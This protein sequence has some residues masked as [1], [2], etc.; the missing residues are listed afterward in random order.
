MQLENLYIQESTEYII[1]VLKADLELKGIHRFADIKPNRKNIQTQCPFHKDGQERKPSFGINDEGMCHCFQADTKVITR[2]GILPISELC[3]KYVEILNGDGEWERVTFNNYGKQQLMK[4]TITANGKNK[5]IYAT[6]SHEWIVKGRKSKVKTKDLKSWMYLEKVLPKMN[7]H[8]EPSLDG[9]I[10]GFCYG[11]GQKTGKHNQYHYR[12]FFYS[13]EDLG[14][15]K[16]FENV[17][18]IKKS[19]A[20]NGKLYDSVCFSSHKNLKEVPKISDESDE[21][22]LGFLAGYF[23]A[24]GNADGGRMSICSYKNDDLSLVRDICV[25]LGI[26]TFP[27]GISNIPKGN[28]GCVTV[29]QDTKAYSLRIVKNT[30]PESFFITQKGKNN[31]SAYNGRLRNR[32]VSVEYTDRYEDVYCCQTSTH[33]FALDDYILTGNCFTCGWAGTIDRMISEIHLKYDNGDYG[34]KWLMR[35]FNST[36]IENRK[37]MT[38]GGRRNAR[39]NTNTSSNMDINRPSWN[40][41][42]LEGNQHIIKEEEL[43]KYRYIHP[44]MYERGL[45]DEIIEMLDIGY[46]KVTRCLTFPVLDINGNCVFVARRSVDIK[47]FNYPAEVEKPVYQ[48]YRF[49]NGEYKTALIVE[50]FLNCATAWK[51]NVPSMAL[52]GTGT[53]E[54]YEILKRLPVREYILALDPDEAGRKATQRFR[55]ALGNYKRITELKYIDSRDINDLQEEFL[56]LEKIL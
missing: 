43:E 42:Q 50:S 46:D 29:K 39:F 1:Q 56:D 37:V 35:H 36:Q 19:I 9:I 52:I 17:G 31:K 3:N 40:K 34:R 5:Y 16:Y 30:V 49:K 4:L 44:Y 23:V 8:I 33:S 21:Y 48:A 2:N 18:N 22:L 41:E 27:I 25:H 12:C 24:D 13:K 53:T 51:Y 14:I 15:S 38:F 55:K 26:A 10:H 20:G 47:F 11:D 28:R 32:V 54:Q 45:T 7:K 6:D